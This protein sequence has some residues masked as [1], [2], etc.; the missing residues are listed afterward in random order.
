MDYNN[1][2]R[3]PTLRLKLAGSTILAATAI[4]FSAS[5]AYAQD[6][7]D[8]DPYI[9]SLKACQT[10]ADDAARLACYDAAVGKVVTASDEGEVRIVDKAVVTKTKRGLFGLGIP[11]FGL[12]S[13]DD[14]E[15][16]LDLLQSVI[17]KV[18]ISGSTMFITI[19]DGGAVWRI[20][21][22]K[23]RIKRAKPGD[24]VEFKKAAMGSYFIR[25]NGKTGV[26]GSRVR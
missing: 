3:A 4:M 8:S 7:T 10:M 17:T 15:E 22:A 26:K 18:S 24:P 14:D 23:S 25:I 1:I 2:F 12:L 6:T 5:A 9:D 16:K 11:D 20:K 21:N 19:E 13:G